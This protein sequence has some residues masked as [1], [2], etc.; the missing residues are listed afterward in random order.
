MKT[1]KT[2]YTTWRAELLNDA[3]IDFTVQEKK[4]KTMTT[5]LIVVK[6]EMNS[7]QLLDKIFELLDAKRKIDP[8]FAKH[9]VG[10]APN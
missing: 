4:L 6:S 1:S 3:K 8:D 9:N 10:Y 2:T 5:Y 7:T